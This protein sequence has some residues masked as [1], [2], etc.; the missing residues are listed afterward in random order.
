MTEATT[1]ETSARSPLLDF[2]S[3]VIFGIAAPVPRTPMASCD[4]NAYW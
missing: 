3:M 4:Q 2:G 1:V